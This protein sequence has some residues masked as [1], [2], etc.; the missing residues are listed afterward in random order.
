[1]IITKEG[2]YVCALKKISDILTICSK[3]L[4]RCRYL[5]SW[6][7]QKLYTSLQFRAV[8]Q[9]SPFSLNQE[10]IFLLELSR[11]MHFFDPDLKI[12]M[13]DIWFNRWITHVRIE[14]Q[15]NFTTTLSVS[16]RIGIWLRWKFSPFAIQTLHLLFISP[17]S[18]WRKCI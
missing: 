9:S 3:N 1:M 18:W 6:N 13:R 2:I 7:L 10:F 17:F 5:Y 8:P 4:W 12:K 15:L 14:S 16:G 11:C